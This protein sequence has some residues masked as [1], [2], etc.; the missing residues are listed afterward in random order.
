MET[1][2]VEK[3]LLHRGVVMKK[4]L[5][6]VVVY[7]TNGTTALFSDVR[8]TSNDGKKLGFKYLGKST[9]V[10]RQAS[11]NLKAIAGYAISVK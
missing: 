2:S 9:R 7:F 1:S 4:E 3:T 8:D 6:S 5:V 11:F 10:E